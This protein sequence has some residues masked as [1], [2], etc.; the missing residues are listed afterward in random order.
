MSSSKKILLVDD[1]PTELQLMAKALANKGYELETAPDGEAALAHIMRS[2]PNLVL[3]DVIMPRRN[4]YQI[5]RQIKASPETQDIK[6]ILV[7]G[8]DQDT[9]RYWGMRQGAD[10]YVTKP[11][12]DADLVASVEKHLA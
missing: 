3:L 5:C 4:G 12:R 10:D 11:F 9:D 8:K 1:S 2:R 7:T 6:V